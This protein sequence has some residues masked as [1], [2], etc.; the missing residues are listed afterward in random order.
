MPFFTR[1]RRWHFYSLVSLSSLFQVELCG[2]FITLW[3]LDLFRSVS[4][5]VPLCLPLSF[6]L[7]PS[8]LAEKGADCSFV[9]E[10]SSSSSSS[11]LLLQASLSG[12]EEVVAALLRCLSSL[13]GGAR[14]PALLALGNEEHITPLMAAVAEG[15]EGVAT[16]REG[17]REREGGRN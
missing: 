9:D 7:S 13:E 6:S 12:Q 10:S 17:E 5:S 11:S 16:V 1:T 2:C 14:L 15:H 8:L 4:V 3:S